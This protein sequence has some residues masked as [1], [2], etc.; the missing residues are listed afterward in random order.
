MSS[1]G[2]APAGVA[3]PDTGASY[4]TLLRVAGPVLL[5]SLT[6]SVIYLTDSLFVGR[7][8]EVALAAVGLGALLFYLLTT[9]GAGLGVALQILV[10]RRMAQG[11]PGAARRLFMAAGHLALGLSLTLGTGLWLL[12]PQLSAWLLPAAA[13]AAQLS[14]Y[15]QVVAVAVPA[16]FGW[17][18]LV[19][20]YTGLGQTRL[21]PWSTLGIALSN[22]LGSYV[23]V[24]GRLGSSSLGIA[25]AAWAAVLS[26]TVGLLVLLGGLLWPR[27]PQLAGWLRKRA[28]HR[29]ASRRLWR[30]AGPL[31][32]RQVVEVSGW[33]GF[34][35]LVG[36]LGARA[37]A[38]SNITRSLYTFI[39]LPALGLATALQTVASQQVG[40]ERLGAVLP[41]VRRAT[42]LALGFGLLAA[43]GLLLWPAALA[44]WFTAEPGLV[45]ATV[46]VLRMLAGLLLTFSAATMLFHAVVG[47]GGGDHSLGLEVLATGSYLLTAWLGVRL[48]WPLALVWAAELGYWLVL[49]ALSWRYLRRG[50]WQPLH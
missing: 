31:V 2:P 28:W 48:G 16:S 42:A 33:L 18:W 13:V 11:R 24:W 22:V 38:V 50:E 29:R 44:R 1:P 3:A 41:T 4:G 36:Q 40:Q 45:A 23:W 26:E 25:G 5:G 6:Q 34:F 43:A 32:L 37:L 27:T 14:Q 8:G 10:A 46:P 12:A 20:L 17:L 30:F 19:G 15:L 21:I 9:V 47:V 7:L 35:V 49:G 39:S